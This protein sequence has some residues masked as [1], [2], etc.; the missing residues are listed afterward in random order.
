[1]TLSPNLFEIFSPLYRFLSR[2]ATFQPDCDSFVVR[3]RPIP[4]A[5]RQRGFISIV[6][7]QDMQ[8]GI[9]RK[10]LTT[11]SDNGNF[12]TGHQVLEIQGER[13]CLNSGLSQRKGT[14][15][16]IFDQMWKRKFMAFASC[17]PSKALPNNLLLSLVFSGKS[18]PISASQT[19]RRSTE[20]LWS[21]F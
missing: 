16:P 17:Q 4:D 12:I 20:C 9:P 14:I 21:R 19:F 18:C 5:D 3:A 2:T 13:T 7:H 6:F 11:T 1:M 8:S 15:D 10:A